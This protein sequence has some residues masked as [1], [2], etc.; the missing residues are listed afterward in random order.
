VLDVETHRPPIDDVVAEI[1]E[2]WLAGGAGVR[3]TT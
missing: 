1:Y 2:A 3:Q